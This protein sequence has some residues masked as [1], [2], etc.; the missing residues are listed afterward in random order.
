M[1][2]HFND[3]LMFRPAD[4]KIY[5]T[6]MIEVPQN[7]AP[8]LY[9][10]EF[11]PKSRIMSL[12]D[13]DVEDDTFN[14][15]DESSFTSASTGHQ[16]LY[17]YYSPSSDSFYLDEQDGFVDDSQLSPLQLPLQI[18][19]SR[20]S[21]KH[22]HDRE[23]SCDSTDTITLTNDRRPEPVGPASFLLTNRNIALDTVDEERIQWDQYDTN[24]SNKW[25]SNV[26]SF[27]RSTTPHFPSNESDIL[28][29]NTSNTSSKSKVVLIK[30]SK[31]RPPVHCT[32]DGSCVGFGSDEGYDDEDDY[33]VNE[34]YSKKE[35]PMDS[36]SVF[37]PLSEDEQLL[38]REHLY[39]LAALKIQA[40]WR[41]YRSRK[42]NK[43]AK[44][45]VLAGLVHISESINHRKTN[46]LHHKIYMLDRRVQEETAM[47]V[48]FEKAMEDM[49]VLVDDQHKVLHERVEQEINMRQAY[50]RK[51]E[52]AL[53][54]IQP[55]ESRL[56]RETNERVNLE[57][58]MSRVVDQLQDLK[59][60]VKE[61]AEARKSIQKKLNDAVDEIS[62]LK[63]RNNGSNNNTLSTSRS[64]AAASVRPVSKMSV[65]PSTRPVSRMATRTP[66][67]TISS[68]GAPVTQRRQLINPT[69]RLTST[70]NVKRTNTQTTL[71]KT[72]LSRKA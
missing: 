43:S 25:Y 22:R 39:E 38:D 71:R 6:Q 41:G 31:S 68:S 4:D 1:A 2:D 56:R 27:S 24:E 42:Q 54:Q 10:Y 13:Y 52:H 49:T 44:M 61:E 57:S 40:V 53:S 16:N 46:Q 18:T 69:L 19:C 37:V 72:T 9:S 55:L 3:T 15:F 12:V 60:Q 70:E 23:L 51:M 35:L 65:R 58:L 20:R 29:D 30:L 50:E 33:D 64:S 34:L 62:Q 63:K 17:D 26:H 67:T 5:D 59:I 36:A 48:A 7:L 28:G 47:R 45:C 66:S 8:E 21:E 14:F 32:S 11:P